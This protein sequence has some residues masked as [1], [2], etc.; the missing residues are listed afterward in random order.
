MA[1]PAATSLPPS[2]ALQSSDPLASPAAKAALAEI[3]EDFRLRREKQ[4]QAQ[5][6]QARK[7][8]ILVQLPAILQQEYGL[9]REETELAIRNSLYNLY[10]DAPEPPASVQIAMAEAKSR[11]EQAAREQQQ[12]V[13]A[14]EQYQYNL[15]IAARTATEATF[16][17]SVDWYDG[18][19]DEY[20]RDL[21]RTAM[22]LAADAEQ[23]G[24]YADVSPQ[25]VQR[26]LETKLAERFG[27]A[28]SKRAAKAPA[29]PAPTETPPAPQNVASARG[30]AAGASGRTT[31]GTVKSKAQADAEIDA[32]LSA[33]LNPNR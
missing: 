24:V 8:D 26:Y 25:G 12:A 17:V 14:R 23:R 15:S 28:A 21:E 2:T 10:P 11:R 29:T 32:L 27:K 33:M 7:P 20:A 9:S 5:A 3:V 16:P 4:A 18:N 1:P 30:A 31:A 22:A 19:H 13:Q 6:A